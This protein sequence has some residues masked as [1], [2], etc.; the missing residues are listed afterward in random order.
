V[1]RNVALAGEQVPA[2]GVQVFER[3]LPAAAR[4]RRRKDAGQKRDRE[5]ARA[6][7]RRKLQLR[8][9]AISRLQGA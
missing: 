4:K 7:G 3:A 8:A 2:V 1:P 6:R 5:Q 9:S